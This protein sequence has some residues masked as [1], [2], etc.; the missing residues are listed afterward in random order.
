MRPARYATA[1]SLALASA[2]A[3]A[4]PLVDVIDRTA[5]R[6]V[7]DG[8]LNDWSGALNAVDAAA[9]VTEGAAAWRGADDASFAFAVGRDAG[10][11]YVAAE[12]RD[13]RVVRSRQHRP[14]DD[15]L[16]LTLAIPNG[17]RWT[18]WEI[19]LMPGEPGAYA[20]VARLRAARGRPL[21]GA[22][23]VEAP[24]RGGA[25]FTLEA[26]LPWAALPGLRDALG[27]ARFRV[28]YADSD[29][30][31][32]PA[33][34]TV[35]ANGGGDARR[36]QALPPTTASA[37]A[38]AAA[39]VDQ[40]ARF[41]QEHG[42]AASVRPVLDR[43]ADLAGSAE[44]ERVVVLPRHIVALGSGV[45]AGEGYT[46]VEF[47]EGEVE[48]A[49]LVE[50]TGDR[51]PELALTLRV[52][53]GAFER[54]LVHVYAMGAEG[55]F[56]RLFAREVGRRDGSN[57]VLNAV[58]FAGG[59]VAFSTGEARGYTA[60]TWPGAEE[61]GVPAPLTPWG[62]RRGETYAWSAATRSFALAQS[63]PNA[64]VA[65]VVA[66]RAVEAP[67]EAP[68]VGPDVAGVLRLFCEREH[69]APGARPSLRVTG[70]AAE[71]PTPEQLF[72]YGHTLVLV[73]P[74]F[75]GGRAYA[76]VGLAA[77][78]GDEVISLRAAD[79]TDDGRVEAIVTVRRTVTLPVHGVSNTS[80]RDMVLAYSF[81]P[82]HR[83]RVFAVEVARR[84]GDAA[85]VNRLVLPSDRRGS[86]LAVET[87]EARGWTRETYPFHDAPP[88][89]YEPLA[90]P[91]EGPRRAVWRWS[92]S[93]MARVP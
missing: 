92:G 39:S 65:Q 88:Q 82:S 83:G 40:L 70:D 87:V 42:V 89:G 14:V 60:A 18:V 12:V 1:L 49:Q 64:E 41:R 93:A 56:E 85:I 77:G 84:S 72:V 51:R 67:V 79:V 53:A 91:W 43:R 11:L 19:A 22:Q 66:P 34:E 57:R 23:V 33:V 52:A 6:T 50:L 74:R 29:A 78:P 16:V 59:R 15:A 75:L 58:R 46:F 61:P 81:E 2:A 20:G 28:A 35:I 45:A 55:G 44:P 63:T 4:D 32:R 13:D 8:V 38:V 76:S 80:Q 31:A 36:P 68:E 54:T 73:G 10:A 69:I 37:A 7:L 48:S 3:Q 90:L 30:E 17:A 47:P 24:L 86:E 27:R 9:Q 5:V 62:P 26:R 21:A 25:G 71:D